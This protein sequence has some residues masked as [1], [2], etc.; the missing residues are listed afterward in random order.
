MISLIPNLLTQGA[1]LQQIIQWN[2][3]LLNWLLCLINI[4]SCISTLQMT[5]FILDSYLAEALFHGMDQKP[6]G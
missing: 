5:T 2:N 4:N 6:F 3:N 1:I